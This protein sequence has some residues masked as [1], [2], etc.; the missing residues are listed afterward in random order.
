MD[1][2]TQTQHTNQGNEFIFTKFQL[3]I[4][5]I[6]EC[7]DINTLLVS[8]DHKIIYANAYY[9][10]TT[11]FDIDS[12]IGNFC[13]QIICNKTPETIDQKVCPLAQLFETKKPILTTS[14]F[15]DKDKNEH[16][17]HTVVS[18]IHISDTEEACLYMIIP[19]Q[20]KTSIETEANNAFIKSQNLLDI[21]V[22]HEH[23]NSEIKRI[24]SEMTKMR[25]LLTKKNEEFDTIY[26]DVIIREN[27]M[28]ELKNQISEL[29]NKIEISQNRTI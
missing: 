15:F 1:E 25:D 12:V 22:Q 14:A 10:K 4:I 7:M 28:A 24:D 20:D 27:K 16:L 18:L 13:Y 5:S 29:E 9:L 3:Q 21:L 6:L 8:R 26:S 23:K 2:Q 17:A 11:G 19:V